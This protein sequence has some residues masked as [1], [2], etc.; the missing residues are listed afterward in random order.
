LLVPQPQAG[1]PTLEESGAV[2]AKLGR[3]R[4]P[5]ALMTLLGMSLEGCADR[6]GVT[7]AQIRSRMRHAAGGETPEWEKAIERA[8]D[9]RVSFEFHDT[10]LAEVTR[11]L[12]ETTRANILLDPAIV[13]DH[14]GPAITLTMSNARFGAALG[15]IMG[16]A[17]TDFVV[18]NRAILISTPEVIKASE[19][20]LKIYDARDLVLGEAAP[21][22]WKL[23][24]HG[25]RDVQK[26]AD[27]GLD[28]LTPSKLVEMVR[29]RIGASE[30]SQE[31]GT[32][33]EERGGKLVVMQRPEAHAEIARFLKA[34]RQQGIPEQEE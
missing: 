24:T 13:K 20:E 29:A 32:S 22:P 11:S 7:P 18:K 9:G 2:M 6:T 8:L 5:L 12:R 33:V 19:L 10:P 34:L 23:E 21:L 27:V 25:A 16:L 30:W 17:G 28:G 31:L 1:E 14:G 26:R 3:N 4:I 15:R